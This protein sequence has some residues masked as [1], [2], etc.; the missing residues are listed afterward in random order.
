MCVHLR[1]CTEASCQHTCWTLPPEDS[2]PS[3]TAQHS[4]ALLLRVSPA[5]SCCINH[6]LPLSRPS[7]AA[8]DLLPAAA[9]AAAAFLR[10]AAE[11]VGNSGG[12][13]GSGGD[14]GGR[15][16]AA[17]V[18]GEHMPHPQS[19]LPEVYQLIEHNR[20]LKNRIAGRS[21]AMDRLQCC[22]SATTAASSC[23]HPH[24]PTKLTPHLLAPHRNTAPPHTPS[25]A[26]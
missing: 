11:A 16:N 14:G 8:S 21:T 15:H 19:N 20:A 3:N 12:G 1:T 10:S 26:S 24:H 13:G 6:C 2:L 22:S 25:P 4:T 7:L 17:L 23:H 9:S 18:M 5:A